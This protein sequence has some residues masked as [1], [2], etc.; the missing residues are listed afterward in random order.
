MRDQRRDNFGIIEPEGSAEGP[1]SFSQSP[2]C[3]SSGDRKKNL[4]HQQTQLYRALVKR[5]EREETTIRE[6]G[7]EKA[8]KLPPGREGGRMES[9]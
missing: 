9:K 4:H 6:R 1:P 2:S 5:P 8:R 3:S 7:N